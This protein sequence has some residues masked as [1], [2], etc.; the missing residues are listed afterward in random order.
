MVDASVLANLAT[1]DGAVVTDHRGLLLAAGAILRNPL[2]EADEIGSI[3]EGART[4]AAMAAARVG[5]VLTMSEDGV[6]SF[7]DGRKI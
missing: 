3:A 4:T 7:F 1:V 5:A 2:P 6:I